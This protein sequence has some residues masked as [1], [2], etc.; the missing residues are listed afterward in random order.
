ME[1][2]QADRRTGF[3]AIVVAAVGITILAL[4]IG[5]AALS[6]PS[7]AGERAGVS[8][9]DQRAATERALI[10]F[11]SGERVG[12]SV[13]DQRAATERALIEFRAGERAS[14]EDTGH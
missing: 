8:V 9:A 13:A 14:H 2:G 11:R 6:G 10:D 12:V 4:W 7:Q 1:T 5:L 3:G